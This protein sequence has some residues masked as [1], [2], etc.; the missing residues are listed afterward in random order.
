MWR[1]VNPKENKPGT[2]DDLMDGLEMKKIWDR[3][4]GIATQDTLTF[5]E[6]DGLVR[7]AIKAQAEEASA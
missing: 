4:S 7:S 5:E 3:L 6:F 2:G 1:R